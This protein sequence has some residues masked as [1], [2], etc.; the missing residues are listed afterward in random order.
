MPG[1]TFGTSLWT[2]DVNCTYIRRLI[3][4]PCSGGCSS[5]SLGNLSFGRSDKIKIVHTP[6]TKYFFKNF[7]N[8]SRTYY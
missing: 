5:D 1:K 3:Y 7:T 8:T 2:Q 4:V 6:S